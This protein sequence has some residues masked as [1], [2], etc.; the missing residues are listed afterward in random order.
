MTAQLLLVGGGESV[1]YVWLE[2]A[3]ACLWS[4]DLFQNTL[5]CLSDGWPGGRPA[6]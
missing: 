1:L 4:N 6:K 5:T 3:R 2:Y